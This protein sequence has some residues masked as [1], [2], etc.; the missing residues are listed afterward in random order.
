MANELSAWFRLEEGHIYLKQVDLEAATSI[1]GHGYPRIEKAKVD[2]GKVIERRHNALVLENGYS[3]IVL[4][5]EMGRL[6]SLVDKLSGHEQLWTNAVARP[7]FGQQNDLGWWMVWGGVEYT[8]PRGE[9]GTTWALRWSYEIAEN[10]LTRKAVRMSVLDPKTK[11]RQSLEFSLAPDSAALETVVSIRNESDA[12]VPFSHWVNPM[13]A[14][15]GRGELT[16]KTEF[17]VPAE[18]MRVAERDFNRWMLGERIQPWRDNPLRLAEHW[19]EIGD[20]LAVELTNG[21]YS[22]FSHEANEGVAR[23]FDLRAN[24]GL[25]IWTWGYPPPP[26]RQKEYSL[27]PNLGY[28][29]MWGGSVPDFRDESLKPLN[30][31]QT[32]RWVEWMFPYRGTDGLTTASK[33]LAVNFSFTSISEDEVY[34]GL[35]AARRLTN[36]TLTVLLPDGTSVWSTN[37]NLFP[38]RTVQKVFKVPKSKP[39]QVQFIARI[40]TE[41]LLRAA[42]HSAPRVQ[43]NSPF[44][45]QIPGKP[46]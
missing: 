12:V 19:R 28:V 16:A 3:R 25:D 14:P 4:L 38:G 18:R 6:Y 7:L 13:W 42:A 11:L 43:W 32:V 41:T 34:L 9:H 10:S 37:S 31:G 27:V 20:L 40:G 30:P 36:V 29:E 15:G 44:M 45:P 17:I 24:P 26:D 39:Q 21:F 1:D 22:A 8:I 5:P 33:D 2:L 23:V 35:C 46:N